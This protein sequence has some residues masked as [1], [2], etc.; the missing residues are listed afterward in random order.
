MPASPEDVTSYNE[1]QEAISAT[2]DRTDMDDSRKM[3][4][5]LC[6]AAVNR[7]LRHH[8]LFCRSESVGWRTDRYVPLPDDWLKSRN[9]EM[10]L[11]AENPEIPAEPL[12]G[13]QFQLTYQSPDVIDMMKQDDSLVASGCHYTYYSNVLEV[14]PD[15][16]QE[17]R[18]ILEYYKKVPKLTNS[19]PTNWLL[20]NHPDI[21]F[22]GSLVH[23][24]PYLRDD[25]RIALWSNLYEAG[26]AEL[27]LEHEDSM[28]SGSRIVRK[29]VV[30]L[31]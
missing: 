10:I 19:A 13:E 21:Y 14:F 22:Y 17:F 26:I 1:L 31:G 4:I 6:E 7:K 2:I 23:S 5:R 28:Q 11:A 18:L 9:V 29:T 15:P 30:A 8:G 24:A 16:E 12:D 25:A 20:A 3:W 27:N